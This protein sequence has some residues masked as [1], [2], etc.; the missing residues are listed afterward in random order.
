MGIALLMVS[1]QTTVE[2]TADTSAPTTSP[3]ADTSSPS[4]SPSASPTTPT[5]VPTTA[6]PTAPS[7]SPSAAPTVPTQPPSTASPT[8]PT[9]SPTL[10]PTPR[11]LDDYQCLDNP[12]EI[13][14]EG[15]NRSATHV[16]PTVRVMMCG[17]SS[18]CAPNVL[19]YLFMKEKLGMNVTWYPTDDYDRVWDGEFWQDW[20]DPFAYPK[21]YFE[22]LYNDSMDMNFEIWQVQLIR[23][24]FDD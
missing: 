4:T 19:A 24:G 20:V 23:E 5:S 6:A 18:Q 21:Y 11:S 8:Q 22:W 17:Y 16:L 7:S 10:R 14:F 3:T 1:G 12:K 2:P 13:M 15:T 9:L